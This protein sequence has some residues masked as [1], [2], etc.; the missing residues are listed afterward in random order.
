MEL[1]FCFELSLPR[2]GSWVGSFTCSYKDIDRLI[3]Y[4]K[5][6]QEHHRKITFEE[7]YRILLLEYGITPDERFFP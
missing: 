3:D 7:E 4:V 5:N 2:M 1:M 6:Q